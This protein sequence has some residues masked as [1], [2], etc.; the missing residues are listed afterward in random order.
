MKGAGAILILIFFL[1]VL[2]AAQDKTR[3]HF[4]DVTA[5]DLSTGIYSIDSIA[6]AV[7]IADIGSSRIEGNSKGSFSLVYKR[8]RRI[9]ILNKNAYSLANVTIPLYYNGDAEE[10]VERLKAV[11]YNLQD[12]KVVESEL[13]KSGIFDE[14]S[15]RNKALKK[16]TLPNVKEGSIIEY[17]YTIVSD[18]LQYLR[19]WEFQG[20]YPILRSE[21]EVS[22]PEFLG[23]ITLTHGYRHFDVN[24]SK[25]RTENFSVVIARS[26]LPSSRTQFSATVTDHL[27]AFN[28]VPAFKEQQYIFSLDDHILKIEFQLSEVRQP[29]EPRQ[30]I[31]NWEK[32]AA[33]LMEASYF[34]E[35]VYKDNPWMDDILNSIRKDVN[36]QFLYRRIYDWVRENITCTDHSAIFTDQTLKNVYKKKSGN[37]AEVNL[38]LTALLRHEGFD[39]SPVLISTRNNGAAYAQFPILSQYNYV[40]CRLGLG[41]LTWYLDASEPFLG[42]GKL[43]LRCFNGT[44]RIINKEAKAVNLIADSV[45]EKRS[46]SVFIVNDENGKLVGSMQQ[47]AGYYESLEMRERLKEGGKMQLQKEAGSVL[48]NEVKIEKF[49]VDS[50]N[51]L[52]EPLGLHYDFEM[53]GLKSDFIYFNPLLT[54]VHHENPF[55]SAERLYPV[56]MPFTIDETYTL[57][58]EVPNGYIVEELP[59]SLLLKL[60]QADDGLYE[61]RI[62]QSGNN[63][64]LRSH[65]RLARSFYD[66]S[67]YVTL[68]DFFSMM[69]KKQ[70]EQIVFRKIK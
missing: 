21:Y 43:P 46:S 44:A 55:K 68:R 14:R 67:E 57:Q 51:Q 37:V 41:K 40:I 12:G 26:N 28:N 45:F 7:I 34:G 8:Y 49:G 61:Y 53:E 6:D 25:E 17:E 20:R 10:S 15:N 9:H 70:N 2:V 23:Y 18:F 30:V 19:A 32:V 65:F 42:F 16:F 11:T 27:Y 69:I 62:S 31:E 5:K 24:E 60:N 33:D 36:R 58:M 54:E 52:N 59:R 35:D 66:A 4:G 1:P 38:F 3:I 29:L 63:I 22:I 64:S 56:E 48:G 47:V 39:A 13:D 50:V